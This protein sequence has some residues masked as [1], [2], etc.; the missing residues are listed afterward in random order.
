[1]SFFLNF[2]VKVANTHKSMRIKIM[3]NIGILFVKMAQYSDACTSFEWIMSE[4][5]DFKTG[6]H[7]VLCYFALGDKDRT[8]RG[9]QQLLEVPHDGGDDEDKYTS[10]SDDPQSNL[11]LEAIRNDRLRR[12]ERAKKHEAEYSILMAAKLIAPV[13]RKKILYTYSTFPHGIYC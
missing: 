6:L 12:I 10:V 9:F 4:Q 11:V 1:M 5:P 8:K 2:C 3:H 13:M 7:L